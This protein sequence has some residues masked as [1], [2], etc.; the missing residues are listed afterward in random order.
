VHQPGLTASLASFDLLDLVQA[1][2]LDRRALSLVVRNGTQSLGVLHFSQGEL[3]WAEFQELR[4]EEAFI[5][6]AAQKTGSIEQLP[7]D[8]QGERNVVQ[9]LSR[10]IMQAASHRD[11]HGDQQSPRSP[12][13]E[14]QQQQGPSLSNGSGAPHLREPVRS[15]AQSSPSNGHTRPP[16]VELSDDAPIPSWVREVR[17]AALSISMQQTDI[18]PPKPAAGASVDMPS[19]MPADDDQ[20][21]SSPGEESEAPIQP[22]LPLS[23]LNGKMTLPSLGNGNRAPSQPPSAQQEPPTVPL[24]TVQGGLLEYASRREPFAQT[25]SPAAP[26]TTL[27]P[28]EPPAEAITVRGA[29]SAPVSST[30]PP[31]PAPT[32][33]GMSAE[34]SS[35]PSPQYES[36]VT[37]A[38]ATPAGMASQAEAKP[39]SLSILEQ[40]AYGNLSNNGSV[41]QAPA[42][43]GSVEQTA[44]RDEA[45]PAP[46]EQ[47]A[48][49]FPGDVKQLQQVLESFVDQVGPACIATALVRTDGSLVADY[50]GRRSQDQELNSPA[51]HLAHVMQSSLRALLMGGWGDLEET[52]ITGSTHLVVLRRLGRPEKGL[53]H[54]AVLERSGNPGLCRVRMRGSESALLQSL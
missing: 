24:P 8:G 7:W 44:A 47:T 6:L 43:N 53:F 4:G 11:T 33:S 10:L 1:I 23:V 29:M 26:K 42:R 52:M 9:P 3:L 51:Y 17:A 20:D 39:S 37:A 25:A 21:D 45:A 16:T 54:V 18:L 34:T 27:R 32:V 31:S 46:L 12:D 35:R 41:E 30:P 15:P 13:Q 38:P 36:A 40:L 14:N 28:P 2:H 49:E 48:P 22:T 19:A 50:I 5:A